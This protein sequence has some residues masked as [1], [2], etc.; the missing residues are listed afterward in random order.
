MKN[1]ADSFCVTVIQARRGSSRMPDK[2][3]QPLNGTPVLTWVIERC[4]MINSVDTV[5]VAIP[6]DPYNDPVAELALKSGALVSRGSEMD[7]LARYWH[8]VS[9][10]DTKYVMR[11]TSDCPFLDPD[12]CQQLLDEVEVAGLPYGVTG[13]L[14][15]GIVCEVFTKAVLE[16]AFHKA[17]HAYD[18]EHVTL[19]I[20]RK[21]KDAM[22]VLKGDPEIA[23]TNRWVLDY[24]ED[25]ELLAKVAPLLSRAEK[26]T[27]WLTILEIMQNNP[28][29]ADINRH[30]IDEWRTKTD[31]IYKTTGT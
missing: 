10:I 8:A 19:W 22:F 14:P 29:F 21:C 31:K 26:P 2:I 16:E 1:K 20:K 7:V 9:D 23:C 6:E 12:I 25:Y 18:R 5:I 28:G 15:N 27:S 30:R 13:Q 11:V 3:L 17:K 24:P 4:Q